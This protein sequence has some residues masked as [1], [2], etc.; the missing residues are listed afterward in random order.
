MAKKK[1]TEA[2]RQKR[3]DDAERAE[4]DSLARRSATAGVAGDELTDKGRKERAKK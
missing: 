3:L 1:E 4:R 2:A